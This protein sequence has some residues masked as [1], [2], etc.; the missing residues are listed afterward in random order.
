MSPLRSPFI[1]AASIGFDINNELKTRPP[2]KL[3]NQLGRIVGTKES[4]F[5]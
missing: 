4:D 1:R 5:A 2:L 3:A